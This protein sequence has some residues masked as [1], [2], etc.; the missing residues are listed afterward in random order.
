MSIGV[1][2]SCLVCG[3]SN[4]ERVIDLGMQPFADSFIPEDRLGET[5]P[6]H[7]LECALCAGCGQLQTVHATD[8]RA[9]Y[10]DCEYSYTSSNSSFARSHWDAYAEQVPDELKLEPG[11]AVVEIG[12]NDGYLAQRLMQRGQ[13]VLGVDASP[14][15]ARLAR[16]RGVQTRV[17]LFDEDCADE[18][19][20][21]EGPAELVIAN[22]VLNHAED[23]RAFCRAAARL[24]GEEGS[25]VFEQPYWPRG[26]QERK[27]DQ[28]YHEHV[29][30]FSVRS[31]CALAEQAGLRVVDVRFV[32]YHGGSLRVYTRRA[33]TGD[34][35]LPDPIRARIR[36]EQAR[37]DFDPAAY[38]EFMGAITRQRDLFLARLYELRAQ[39]HVIGAAGAAAKGNS[40]LCFYNLDR[41]VISWVT[42]PSPHKQ[43]KY[44]P[45][46]RIPILDDA[47]V[48]DHEE[49]F[50]IVLSWN[51]V[52][53]IREK[54]ER[55]NPRVRILCPFE[56]GSETGTGRGR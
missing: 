55:L 44:T 12:S 30:Y 49:P 31:A 48:A 54:L 23:P 37:G 29:S 16:Q 13:R 6:I 7:P 52:G 14:E 41:S 20:A 33:T 3:S 11:A 40:F 43:G 47:V 18:I 10:L 2:S 28:I 38:R 19:R 36:E 32:E 22:N 4:L 15:M 17:A 21:T 51:I 39:G 9:R 5:E 45:L 34:P 24:L 50:V 46:S 25:F 26:L 35:E 42:D 53:L 1:R 56:S 27:F 8:P